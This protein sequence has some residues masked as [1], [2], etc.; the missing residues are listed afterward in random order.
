MQRLGPYAIERPVGQGGLGSVYRAIDERTGGT[1]ALKVLSDGSPSAAARLRREF[2]SL[3]NLRHANLVALLDCGEADGQLYL[4][5]EFIEGTTLRGHLALGALSAFSEHSTDKSAWAEATTEGHSTGPANP[6]FDL[7]ALD[8]EPDSE[9]LLAA[10]KAGRQE[11]TGEIATLPDSV[12]TSLNAPARIA[13]LREGL[14]QICRGL[15]ALHERGL[16]HR[17]LKPGNVLV[18][19]TG[20][21]KLAD[22]GL[23]KPTAAAEQDTET[24]AVGAV[25]GTY[26]YMAPEQARGEPVDHRAD[27]YSLGALLYEL[28]AGRPPF[29][30]ASRLALA[31]AVCHREPP[32]L[33]LL[34]P[35]APLDLCAL[36]HRLLAKNPADRP[37]SVADVLASL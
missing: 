31:H 29:V 35:E 14:A 8:A 18:N 10:A 24:T 12:L 6:G 27:L 1:V 15:S 30:D 9:A 25:V 19:A 36:A 21:V 32:P 16:V 17:D 34:N 2:S 26:R 11:E 37:Q 3:A 33:S 22:F 13:R 20:T 28:L 7:Y 4:A 23:V 5:M